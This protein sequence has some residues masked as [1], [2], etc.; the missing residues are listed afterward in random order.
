MSGEIFRALDSITVGLVTTDS[1]GVVT[2]ANA[3]A[4]EMLGLNQAEMVG[5]YFLTCH[6]QPVRELLGLL[7]LDALMGRNLDTVVTLGGKSIE[8]K[9]SQVIPR[10]GETNGVVTVMTDISEKLNMEKY[11][12]LSL[13]EQEIFHEAAQIMN[14]SLELGHILHKLLDIV[15]QVIEYE[16]CRIYLYPEGSSQLRLEAKAEVQDYSF[17]PGFLDQMAPENFQ[18]G[19]FSSR[20]QDR[21]NYCVQL[22]RGRE[23]LG[24]IIIDLGKRDT[25][26]EYLGRMLANLSSLACLAIKNA[27]MYKKIHELATMDGLTKLYNRQYFDVVLEQEAG[28]CKRNQ[29]PLSLIMVDVNGLKEINDHLG[30]TAGDTILQH[31][32][33]LLQETV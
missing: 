28:R 26:P 23:L 6:P 9:L 15:R 19:L 8:Y 16:S 18:D 11:L 24:C 1:L 27:Q 33:R 10:E 31:A 12:T 25:V 14:S 5:K 20:E 13:T 3:T 2:Y 22:R 21:L 17:E 7:F 32:A 29:R 30:H 4:G